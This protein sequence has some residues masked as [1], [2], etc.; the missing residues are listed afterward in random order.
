MFSTT[1]GLKASFLAEKCV[2]QGAMGHS[3]LISQLIGRQKM[4][5]NVFLG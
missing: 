3:L 1:S 5:T 4:G 2:E